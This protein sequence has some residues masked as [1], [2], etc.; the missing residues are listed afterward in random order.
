MRIRSQFPFTERLTYC[1]DPVG[2]AGVFAVSKMPAYKWRDTER[3]KQIRGDTLSHDCTWLR[4][5]CCV[6]GVEDGCDCCN[7]VGACAPIEKLGK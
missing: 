3:L 5:L 4:T 7:V 1:Y 6:R 2:R